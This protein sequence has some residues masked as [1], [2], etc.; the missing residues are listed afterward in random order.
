MAKVSLWEGVTSVTPEGVTVVTPEGVTGVTGRVSPSMFSKG[1][2]IVQ[3]L[4]SPDML[5][6]KNH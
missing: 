6:S 3:M 4:A 2:D 1:A 5:L